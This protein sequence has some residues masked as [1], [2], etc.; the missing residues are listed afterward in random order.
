MRDRIRQVAL[1]VALALLLV[2]AG[3]SASSGGGDSGGPELAQS[4]GDGGAATSVEADAERA[5]GASGGDAGDDGGTA[6]VQIQNRALIR[7]GQVELRVQEF[8]SSR[9]NLTADV[10]A[11]GGFVSDS[12]QRVNH[13]G[14]NQTYTEGQV[15]LRVPADN[16]SALMGRIEGEGEVL[17]EQTNTRD[18]TNQLVD[19]E[20]RLS[21][22]RAQRDRLRELYDEANT[23][24][25]VLQVERRLTEVQTEI[26]RLE[27]QQ[28]SLE[29][30]VA[31][32]TVTV[33]LREPRPDYVPD[34]S[35][36]YDT[37]VVQAFLESVDGVVVVLRATVV[38]FAF[39]LPYLLAFGTPIALVVGGYVMYR[40]RRGTFPSR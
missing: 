30:Q 15:V 24:A 7:T 27:A 23:T 16:Y 19:I 20:A 12:R 34:R 25:D 21:N 13:V 3:C 10:E 37:P 31:L 5:E 17:S 1:P 38:G 29:R 11:L 35:Q 36:W 28:A 4:S 26:E 18:V 9:A 32:S 14:D 8:E 40:R 2:L 6:N 39:A 22:L 33:E